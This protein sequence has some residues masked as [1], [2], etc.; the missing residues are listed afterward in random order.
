MSEKKFIYASGFHPRVPD[1]VTV[2]TSVDK[3]G[4]SIEVRDKTTGQLLVGTGCTVDPT[5]LDKLETKALYG[6][7]TCLGELLA[8][9]RKELSVMRETCN[10]LHEQLRK[11]K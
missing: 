3:T 8:E 1:T 10:D 11:K 7:I 6:T 9:T 5:T 2:E 4:Y